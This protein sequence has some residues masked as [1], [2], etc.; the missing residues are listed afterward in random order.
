[1]SAEARS[2]E[3]GKVK[4]WWIRIQNAVQKAEVIEK[5]KRRLQCCFTKSVDDEE[6][7]RRE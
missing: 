6:G 1:V 5:T 4:E 2:V 3:R 7:K